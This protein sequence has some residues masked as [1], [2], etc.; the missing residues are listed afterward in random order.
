MR[1]CPGSVMVGGGGLKG[2][3]D[4]PEE[5]ERSVKELFG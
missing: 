2:Y 5:W 4:A 3:K 1:V